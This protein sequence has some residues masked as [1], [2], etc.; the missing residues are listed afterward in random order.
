MASQQCSECSGSL[1]RLSSE[2][3]ETPDW[4]INVTTKTLARHQEL[5]ST[6]TPPEDAELTFIRAV[7]S[8]TGARLAD[9]ER[10]MSRLRDRLRQL[11]DERSVMSIYHAQNRAILSPLRRM[12]PEVLGEIFSWTLPT[13]RPTLRRGFDVNDS[14]W[15]LTHICSRWRA[16][17]ISTPTLWSLLTIKCSDK[18]TDSLAM[19]KTHIERAHML[20]IHFWGEEI[21]PVGPQIE[22]FRFLAEYSPRWEEFRIQLTS[23][24]SAL[25]PS[26]RNRVPLLRRL[27]I[28]W[29]FATSSA[30]IGSIDC[31]QI[32]PALLDVGLFN[33]RGHVP[34]SLPLHQLTRYRLHAPCE[35]HRDMVKLGHNLVEAHID[36]RGGDWPDSSNAINL[37][38]L[39]RLY[40]SHSKFLNYLRV[41][42]LE[43]LAIWFRKDSG[44]TILEHVESLLARSSCAPHRLCF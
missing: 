19:A 12:P 8:D 11:E 37:F 15:V 28:Q 26:L 32:A 3:E 21:N 13:L 20:Q 40:V 36:V 41:P 27:R 6:N 5:L 16:I 17:A 2:S 39:R 25:L 38:S 4:N 1:P 33:G 24:L 18:Q 9:I 23:D 22:M 30:E 14:P 29:G 42:S 43:E 35:M 10:E 7:L 31:F 34:I 44:P